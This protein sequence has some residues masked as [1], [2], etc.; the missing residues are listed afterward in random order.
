M[1]IKNYYNILG[2]ADGEQNP[3]SIKYA[4]QSLSAELHPKKYTA[5]DCQSR[6]ADINEAFLVLTDENLKRE[7]DAYR[8]STATEEELASPSEELLTAIAH[9]KSQAEAFTAH[10]FAEY[11]EFQE[12]RKKNRK[13][14]K[15][16]VWIIVACLFLV[17]F[18]IGVISACP[19]SAR[20]VDELGAYETPQDWV[21]CRFGDIFSISVPPDM[22]F[23]ID[24][25]IEFMPINQFN[26]TEIQS[27]DM[28]LYR[29]V[30]TTTD[31]EHAVICAYYVVDNTDDYLRYN[32]TEEVNSYSREE[33]DKSVEQIMSPLNIVG[34]PSYRWIDINGAKALEAT[35]FLFNDGYYNGKLYMFNNY[36]EL[37]FLVTYFP[38]ELSRYST[39]FENI[40]RTF[41][42]NH[43]Q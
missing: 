38:T 5:Y 17:P 7:Y 8:Q 23:S 37:A 22:E 33:L 13:K 10:F 25:S 20:H 1:V 11:V 28:V 31:G 18:L 42:W 26:G 4:Y 3:E 36:H 29:T 19:R 34:E 2:I 39:E 35:C 12:K 14:N 21:N 32:E 24:E 43:L 9:K 15:H 40:V 6:T 30:S 16:I 41:K 27:E